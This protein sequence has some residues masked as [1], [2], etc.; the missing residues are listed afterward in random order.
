MREAHREA[1]RILYEER[2]NI[3]DTIPQEFYID[4]HGEFESTPCRD[5]PW[6]L[7]HVIS[8]VARG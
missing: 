7:A 5:P 3:E 4:L 2:N 6:R 1:A 8:R